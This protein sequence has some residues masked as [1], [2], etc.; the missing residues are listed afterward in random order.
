MNKIISQGAEALIERRG[1]EILK[2]RIEKSYRIKEIDEK[3]RKLRTRSEG[4]ILE[5]VLTR[6]A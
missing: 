3:I 6:K 4:K 5:K 1:N 2:K